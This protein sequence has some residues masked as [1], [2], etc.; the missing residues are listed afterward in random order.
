MTTSMFKKKSIKL[1]EE[2]SEEARVSKEQGIIAISERGDGPEEGERLTLD[3]MME[4]LDGGV[5]D[6]DEHG[7]VRLSCD[8]SKRRHRALRIAAVHCDRTVVEMVEALIDMHIY[9]AKVEDIVS[10]YH[11]KRMVIRSR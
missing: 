7:T 3:Q 11:E 4:N 8:I 10:T 2:A 6:A 1:A 5:D 9:Y